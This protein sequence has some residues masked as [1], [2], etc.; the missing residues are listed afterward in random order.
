[1]GLVIE[2]LIESLTICVLSGASTV[3]IDHFVEA[4]SRIYGVPV[5]RSPFTMPDYKDCFDPEKLTALLERT[6]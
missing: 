6:L 5:G 3:K 2:L 1:V 4:F